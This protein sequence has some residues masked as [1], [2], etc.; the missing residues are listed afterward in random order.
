MD[1]LIQVRAGVISV[2]TDIG[3]LDHERHCPVAQSFPHY[4]HFLHTY[5]H[6]HTHTCTHLHTPHTQYSMPTSWPQGNMLSALH[7]A[8]WVGT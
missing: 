1:K 6:A 8:Q 4:A 3:G 5:S 2:E 7:H